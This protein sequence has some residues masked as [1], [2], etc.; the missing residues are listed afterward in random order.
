[1]V[2]SIQNSIQN[3]E[4]S[5]IQ[6]NKIFIQFENVGIDQGYHYYITHYHPALPRGGR[7]EAC[8]GVAE[9]RL[10]FFIKLWRTLFKLWRTLFSSPKLDRA[11]NLFYS[12]FAI[13]HI[14]HLLFR[15]DSIS[16]QVPLSV[17]DW[18]SEWLIVSDLE[19]AI[20]S[21]SFVSLLNLNDSCQH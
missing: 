1:M 8:D 13:K 3:F 7:W 2:N 18:V 21:P 17:G 6:F 19:I 9:A 14:K 11:L 16:Y 15:C 5:W 10:T 4:I 20:A 12:W